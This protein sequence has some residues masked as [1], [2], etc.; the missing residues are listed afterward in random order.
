MVIV[1]KYSEEEPKTLGGLTEY[2]RDLF[3]LR[4]SDL[5]DSHLHE[6]F[7]VVTGFGI[8]ISDELRVDIYQT[9]M[10]GGRNSGPLR[11]KS[12]FESSR[13]F[14]DGQSYQGAKHS[15]LETDA[16]RQAQLRAEPICRAEQKDHERLAVRILSKFMD[17]AGRPM[18]WATLDDLNK[19]DARLL[20]FTAEAQAIKKRYCQSKRE[21]ALEREAAK[22][23]DI[24]SMD[25]RGRHM[26]RPFKPWWGPG[27]R[28]F[29]G[30]KS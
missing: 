30:K 8:G 10:D 11:I 1:E 4:P 25:L 17:V 19:I 20:D 9:V 18:T 5:R 6:A 23:F 7:H 3:G 28:F 2:F 24:A 15:F 27:A 26:P 21:R 12:L 22:A 14:I 13:R 16:W 29:T